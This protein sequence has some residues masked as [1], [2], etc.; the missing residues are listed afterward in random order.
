ML[1]GFGTNP[2]P[3]PQP[4]NLGTPLITDS[5]DN[6][7]EIFEAMANHLQI[8]DSNM[9]NS[10]INLQNI[11]KERQFEDARPRDVSVSKYLPKS[12]RNAINFTT[13]RTKNAVTDD[14]YHCAVKTAKYYAGFQRS[15]DIVSWGKVF[16]HVLRQ[17]LLARAAGFI[18]STT[19][20]IDADTFPDGGYLYI[21]LADGSSFSPQST[22]DPNF[23]KNYAARIPALTPGEPRHVFAPLLY[24]VLATHDGNYDELFQETAEFDDG[25]AKIVH[26]HQPPHRNPI[27]EEAD[28]SYPTKETGIH[29]S[30]NDEQILIWYMRQLMQDDSVTDASKR[31]DAPLG[32]LGYHLDVRELADAGNPENPWESLNRVTSRQPLTLARNPNN[33]SE[34]IE[35]GG[36][37]GELPYQVYPSQ[38]DGTEQVTG[39]Q[40]TYWLPMYFANWNGHSMVLPD[41]DAS[42]VYQTTNTNVDSDPYGVPVFDKDGN[43]VLDENGIQRTTGTGVTGPAQNQL[44][45]MYIAGALNSQLRYG[46]S[47]QFR[48]R[49]QDISGGSPS[50]DLEPIN[51]TSSDIATCAFKRYITP[52]QP[53][54]QEIE[55]LQ[56]YDEN[57][58]HPVLSTDGPSELNELNIR[59]PKLGYPAVVYTDKYTNPVERLLNQSNLGLQPDLANAEHRV[60]LGIADPDVSAIEIVVEIETLKLDKLDSVNGKEDYVHLYTT[61]R[62]FPAIDG[63][64]DNYE[65][66]LNIPIEYVDIQGPDKVLNLGNELNLAQDL[67]LSDDIDNLSQLVLPTARMA[68]L[69][70]RAVCEDKET[71]GET[72]A[73]YGV[74][75]EADKRL[76]VR[77]GESFS[78]QLYKASEDET[79]LLVQTPGV[80]QIQG[81]FMQPDVQTVFDGKA[82]TLLFGKT[83]NT[84]LNNVQQLADQLDLESNGLTLN[85]PKGKRAVFG[86]SSRIR[87]TLA[88]D[89]SSITFASKSDLINHW[90]CCVSVEIDRD[91]MWDALKT[92]SFIVKRTY[93]FTHDDQPQA[94]DA[95]IGRIKMIRT[96]SFEA[97]DVPQRNATRIIFID[98]VEPKKEQ[99]GAQPVFPDTIDVSYTLEPQFKDNHATEKDDPEVSA[100][101][102]PITTPPA[103]VPKIVSAGMALSPYVR[104]EKYASSESRKRFLWIEFDEPVQD[105]QDSYF[106]RVLANS[107]DQLISNNHPSLF[108]APEEPPLPIDSENLRVISP[109]SSNDLAGLNAMQPMLKSTS[110]DRHYILPLPPGLHANS[111]E[112]FGFFTYEFRVGHFELPLENPDATPEKVWTTAQGRFGRRLKSNGIQHPAPTL[113]CMPNRDE[114]KLWVTAPYAVAVHDGKNVTANPPRTELW[115]LLYAQVKQADN[116]DYRNILLDDR[117][118]DWRVQIETEKEVNVFERYSENELQLLNDITLKTLKGETAVVQTGNFLKLVDFSKKN[119]SSTKYGTT[120]WSNTEVAQLLATCGLPEDSALSVIVVETLP[121]I[122]NIFDYMTDLQKPG[123]AQAAVDFMDNNQ[124]IAFS[125]EHKTRFGA[126]QG[127]TTAA[128][129]APRKPSPVSDQLGHHRIMRTSPLTKVPE[130]CCTD[131]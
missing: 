103:Q 10:N 102:L 101:T 126:R 96:A 14:S 51:E 24:P 47:Y 60:G 37:E 50:I 83:N 52:I 78:I 113:T 98:A 110:S 68:R 79:G 15:S 35:L 114:D 3:Q 88:P 67:G 45:Q 100:M 41:P 56:T 64:E 30:W 99:E 2:L 119:K 8:F 28:G 70:I 63:N 39:Q 104:D 106:A 53:R 23:I 34:V 25:F 94:E 125:K 75:K 58:E 33:P 131:C 46:S 40:Q 13:P 108:V 69:T 71:E 82:S 91:W 85:A 74:I 31:L 86:C 49:M 76:D 26:C 54:I 1:Q 4:L 84:T 11:P 32:V 66:N 29:C 90:L 117:P 118:L 77:Y 36:F 57:E 105:P 128:A 93:G 123:T 89:G 95:E 19:L 27:E 124:K 6:P 97:L 5:P 9:E 59:R 38:L 92:N 21:D 112:M 17:P 65:A 20:S 18:Y 129:R 7:R 61:R 130:V 109:A 111:D 12:Y 43:P 116:K 121:Q 22:A 62:A 44:N 107:P 87:H 122:T 127:T 73:Y 42:T 72:N 55:A 120:V 48:V 81:I 80:P 115:A 16:A